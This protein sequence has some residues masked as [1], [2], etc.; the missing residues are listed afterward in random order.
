MLSEYLISLGSVIARMR[1]VFSKLEYSQGTYIC[2]Q[3][4][5]RASM[6]YIGSKCPWYTA[7]FGL[8]SLMSME[9]FDV[10]NA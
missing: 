9:I 6:S 10:L 4:N 3:V 5:E 2:R 8:N 1:V 7:S